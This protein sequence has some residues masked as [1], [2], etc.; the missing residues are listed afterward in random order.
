MYTFK[1]TKNYFRYLKE[2]KRF[3][4]FESSLKKL[5]KRTKIFDKVLHNIKLKVS[6]PPH[7]SVAQVQLRL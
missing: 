3:L 4:Q 6:K 1:L 2:F 7:L 5:P